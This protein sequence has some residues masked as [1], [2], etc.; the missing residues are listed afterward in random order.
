MHT[1]LVI[2]ALFMHTFNLI[3]TLGGKLIVFA[4]LVHDVCG[5][6]HPSKGL[7]TSLLVCESPF[8]IALWTLILIIFPSNHR[9]IIGKYI[10][11]YNYTCLWLLGNSQQTSV[12]TH[13]H[14]HTH[15]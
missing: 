13:T 2:F 4:R 12:N 1:N 9:Q 3:L 15:R 5:Q 7:T 8:T 10:C 6:I 11:L 14:T